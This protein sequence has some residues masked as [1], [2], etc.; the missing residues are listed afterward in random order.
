M[1]RKFFYKATLISF[2]LILTAIVPAQSQTRVRSSVD[3]SSILIGEQIQLTLEA[4]IPE[5][6]PIRFFQL[7]SLVHFEILSAAKIDTSNTGT[8]TRLR[9]II[10]ITSFDSGHW[11]IPSLPLGDQAATDSIPV[12]VGYTSPFDSQKPYHD[13]K[14]IIEVN[15]KEV[16]EDNMLWWYIGGGLLV[17]ILA[18]YLLFRKKKVPLPPPA[19]PPID[20]YKEAMDKLSLLVSRRKDSKQYYSELVDIFRIYIFKKKGIHSLQNTSDDL[21]AQ[22]RGIGISGDDFDNLSKAL[23]ASDLVKFAKYIP[24]DDDDRFIFETIKQ[25]IKSIEELR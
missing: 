23:R 9:Q 10:H 17:L 4:D 12:D 2:A 18:L 22:L 7:D 14:D 8:G 11:V 3:R 1:I 24:S 19:P 15:P 21:I 20:P 13:I 6:E 25:S 5:T 16:K